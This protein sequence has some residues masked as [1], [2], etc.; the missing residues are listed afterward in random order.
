MFPVESAWVSFLA[1]GE[2]WHNYHHAFPW[3]YRASELGT[4]L[5]LTGFFIELLAKFGIIFDL[6]EATHNMVK[7][8]VMRTGDKSHHKYGTSEGRSAVKTLFNTW[9]HPLNPSYNSIYLPKPKTLKQNGYALIEDELK[10]AEKDDTILT[11]ENEWL[12]RLDQQRCD[13]PCS[14]GIGKYIIEKTEARKLMGRGYMISDEDNGNNNNEE[15]SSSNEELSNN[16]NIRKRK[17]TKE[18][19][20]MDVFLDCNGSIEELR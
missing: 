10:K 4:P 8:R 19:L 18:D 11:R 6:K 16:N 13:Q 14:E 1:V 2:G 17:S 3:D 12:E 7:N 15:F 5:N 20:N 9:K